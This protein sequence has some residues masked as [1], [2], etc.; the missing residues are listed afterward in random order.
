MI[1]PIPGTVSGAGGIDFKS[2]VQQIRQLHGSRSQPLATAKATGIDV[3]ENA[4]SVAD[5]TQ[6]ELETLEP[7][8]AQSF[9]RRFT[10]EGS[11]YVQRIW[12]G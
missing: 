2:Y 8:G 9:A 4:L 7:T 10:A 3:T 12:W 5:L 6:S 1:S 11:R